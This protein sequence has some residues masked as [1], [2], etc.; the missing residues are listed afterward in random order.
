VNNV[1]SQFTHAQ[2]SITANNGQ[3]DNRIPEGSFPNNYTEICFKDGTTKYDI[4][5][6]GENTDGGNCLPGDVGFVIEQNERSANY[7]EQ[8]KADCLKDGMRLPEPFEFKYA[9][10]NAS[11]FVLNDMTNNWEWASNFALPVYDSNSGVGAALM[12]DSVCSYAYWHWV[13]T[14]DGSQASDAFRC[15]K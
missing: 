11:T 15:V 14:S 6:G 5:V 8:A 3:Y 2:A 13:G 9:C 1:M 12:G 10:V 4:H 7:W